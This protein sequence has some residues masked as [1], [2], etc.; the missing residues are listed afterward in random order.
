MQ[1]PGEDQDG[2]TAGD[3]L[4]RFFG[5]SRCLDVRSWLDGGSP[6]GD[7]FASSQ[8]ESTGLVEPL[9]WIA[10]VE[11]LSAI[12]PCFQHTGVDTERGST[13]DHEVSVL[14]RIE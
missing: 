13:E 8:L 12:D 14:A 9:T 11:N 3:G 2:V 6:C 5:D 7:Q 4:P 1:P 10:E